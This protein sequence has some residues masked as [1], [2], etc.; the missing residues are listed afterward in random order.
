VLR[1]IKK[2]H[3][4]VSTNIRRR[5]RMN[6][7]LLN[8]KSIIKEKRCKIIIKN[9]EFLW[10]NSIS[11]IVTSYVVSPAG[12]YIKLWVCP[13]DSKHTS[14]S[15]FTWTTCQVLSLWWVCIDIILFL[16]ITDTSFHSFSVDRFWLLF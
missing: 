3:S 6:I 4:R 15:H 8:Y 11:V 16:N 1:I 13:D 9:F 7:S 10:F 2:C 12:H 5:W 14:S